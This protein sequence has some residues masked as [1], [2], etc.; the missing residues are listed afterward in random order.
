MMIRLLFS[1]VCILLLH[2]HSLGQNSR[3]QDVLRLR[4]GWVLRGTIIGNTDSLVR[5]RTA[6]GSEFVFPSGN[7]D[8]LSQEPV[9]E[10]VEKN[11][12][13]L[14]DVALGP[15]IAG[16]TTQNGVTT[17]A[18]SLQASVA[19]GYRPWFMVGAGAGA[20]LYATQTL[21][22]FF[23]TI[24]GDWWHTRQAAW[25]YFLDAG[26]SANITQSSQTAAGFR[27]GGV[28]SGGIGW[29]IPFSHHAG[30]SLSVG[31]H[32]QHTSYL[33]GNDRLSED[34]KRIALRA[35]FYL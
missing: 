1:A 31:Y 18:F 12:R 6:D 20:D 17:A 30:F 29:R 5:I 11:S 25:F 23:A 27:G 21:V 14:T 22:P 33:S 3:K 2:Q 9:W 32:F 24:R 4:D 34:Y 26:Y 28:W 35:R 8:R 10:G 13:W 7:V 16:K 15:L 19:Y